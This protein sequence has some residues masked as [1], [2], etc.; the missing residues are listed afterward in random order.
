MVRSFA[1]VE[2]CGGA[3]LEVR[4]RVMRVAQTWCRWILKFLK[5]S[6][7]SSVEK[8]GHENDYEIETVDARAK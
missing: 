2:K 1:M 8:E 6:E 3:S 5:W 4:E 7:I